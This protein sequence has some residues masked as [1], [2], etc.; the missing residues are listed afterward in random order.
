M[1]KELPYFQF[2][3]GQYL[4][5]S[6]QFCSLASQGLYNN[7]CCIYWERRCDLS[8]E[9]LNKK[10][11]EPDLIKELLNEG[12]LK[13]EEGS[14]IIDFLDEQ[15][16]QRTGKHIVNSNN[17]KKG[18]NAR[19]GKYGEAN[20]KI[21]ATP[22]KTDGI[23]TRQDEVNKLSKE[24]KEAIPLVLPFKS[25]NFINTWNLLLKEKKWKINKQTNRNICGY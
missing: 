25:I 20:G 21:I 15:Y 17:G 22:S 1:P 12:I 24:S 3:P 5:G 4:T 18:A 6:I 10:F 19:W 9:Q 23:K 16:S 13:E 11:N 14:I 8:L 2:E 7:I